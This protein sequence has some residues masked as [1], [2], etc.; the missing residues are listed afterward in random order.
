MITKTTRRNRSKIAILAIAVSVALQLLYGKGKT[1]PI[2]PGS[3]ITI[4]MVLL[5]GQELQARSEVKPEHVIC[6]SKY[7]RIIIQSTAPTNFNASPGWCD[8]LHK[9]TYMLPSPAEAL[10]RQQ[11]DSLIR[12]EMEAFGWRMSMKHAKTFQVFWQISS[13]GVLSIQK[14]LLA[15]PW[16]QDRKLGRQKST[17]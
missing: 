17:L 12:S 8:M 3:A 11:S 13:Y 4:S 14:L 5:G 9:R 16:L 1:L 15:R 10:Q 2:I 6:K 7:N